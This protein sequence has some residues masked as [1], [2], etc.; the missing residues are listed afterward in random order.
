MVDGRRSFGAVAGNQIVAPGEGLHRLHGAYGDHERIV[1]GRQDGAV[2][3]IA[4]GVV[5]A[6]VAGGDNHYDA[7][8]P[9]GLHC[10]AERIETVGLLHRPPQR[11]VQHPDVVFLL[12]I[13]GARD[14]RDHGTVRTRAVRIQHAQ[15]DQI[16]AGRDAAQ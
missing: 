8:L 3:L 6:A 9:G 7:R 1:A 14:S 4:E 12:Q 2:P 11:E 10:L 16:G 15:V 5:P 13:D